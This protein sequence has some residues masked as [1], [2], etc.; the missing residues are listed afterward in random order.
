MSGG[1]DIFVEAQFSGDG[2]EEIEF[3]DGTI[4]TSE[5]I[6]SLSVIAPSRENIP[7]SDFGYAVNIGES[8]TIDP[9]EILENDIDQD[10]D[11]LM[12]V[13]VQD[14]I[15]GNVS[16]NADGMISFDADSNFSG[17]GSF[18]YTITD[19]EGEESTAS[20]TIFVS[21]PNNICLLYTSPSPRDATLSR[22]PS[23]A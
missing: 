8:L 10:G 17:D 9:L 16:L 15:G 2:L 11:E 7:V 12:L 20:V 4:V 22:M 1:S 3:S 19:N 13:S 14:S 18:T 23:S 5:D 6:I 21:D